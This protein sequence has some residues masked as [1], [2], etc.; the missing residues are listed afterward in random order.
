[1][2][3]K[4]KLHDFCQLLS[5]FGNLRVCATE[6]ENAWSRGW[7]LERGD[8]KKSQVSCEVLGMIFFEKF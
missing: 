7:Y 5:N 1:M 4:E 6:S 2:K 3:T 8:K